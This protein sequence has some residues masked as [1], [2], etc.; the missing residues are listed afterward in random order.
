M[1]EQTAGAAGRGAP[2]PAHRAVREQLGVYALGH[3]TDDERAA[4]RAHL[5]GCAGCRAEVAALSPLAARLAD[6]DPDRIDE[7]PP[8]PPELGAAV[9][10]R[11][12]A[13]GPRPVDLAERRRRRTRLAGAAAAVG[14]AAAA[15]GVGWIARPG[16]PQGP[17]EQVAVQVADDDISATADI[18]PHTWGVEVKLSGA[19]F[20]AGEVYR[21]VVEET[22]GDAV[23]GGAFLGVGPGQLD[24][25]MSSSVLRQDAAGFQ[26]LD[27]S[28]EVVLS[29]V[30]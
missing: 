21:L 26:V 8:V 13:Q 25:N 10:A 18:V 22:D 14:I 3:G 24:C 28:G 17:L 23:T 16:P 7:D 4:V 6:V 20:T 5:D 2:D 15:F 29:S 19:G 9:L 30:F 11:I 1:N 27:A 12:A